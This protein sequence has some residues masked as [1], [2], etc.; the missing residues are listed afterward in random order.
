M[1][2]VPK[3]HRR[4]KDPALPSLSE[5]D[6][7]RHFTNLSHKN[8]CVDAHF[9]PL[10]SCTMKYNPKV[11]DAIASMTSFA[12]IHPYADEA[13]AQ[14]ALR[15]LYETQGFLSEITGM[16]EFTLQP[17]AGA[18]GELCGLLIAGAHHRSKGSTKT[19]VLIPDSAHGTNAATAAL[20]GYEVVQ[21]KTDSRGHVE[22]GM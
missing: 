14:G 19:K 8:F 11:L 20:C 2:W 18:H 10:G 22:S 13:D 16:D 4:V 12:C 9:Y 6:V 5:L 1:K 17:A 21:V 15:V 7:V 3:E